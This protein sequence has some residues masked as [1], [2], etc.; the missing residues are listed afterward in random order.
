MGLRLD[1]MDEIIEGE[2]NFGLKP[3]PPDERDFKLGAILKLPKP[4]T[5]PVEFIFDVPK[6]ENQYNTDFCTAF[7]TGYMSEIQEG[8]DIE[9][10]WTFAMSKVISDDVAEW[11]QDIRTAMKTHIKYGALNREN[12]PLTL[13]EKNGDILREIDNWPD[14]IEF[15]VEK[16]KPYKKKSFFKITGH[17][18]HFDNIRASIYEFRDLKRAVGLG[19]DW[20]WN[21]YEP[22]IPD[23]V[24]NGTGHMICVVGWKTVDNEPYL[25]IQNSYGKEVGDEGKHYFPRRV[26]N[27]MVEKYGAYMFIDLPKEQAKYYLDNGILLTDNWVTGLWKALRVFFGGLAGK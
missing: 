10:A 18:D 6:V 13:D 15:W 7:A 2:R 11:G 4:E 21:L 8:I 9:P 22:M 12:S 5:L 25:V 17:Y 27:T 14:N 19:V 1:N 24:T 20:A 23:L 16:A 26:I 3:T